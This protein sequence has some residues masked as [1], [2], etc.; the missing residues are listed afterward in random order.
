[1]SGERTVVAP[2][3]EFELPFS[4]VN[5]KEVWV[6]VEYVGTLTIV[7][8]ILNTVARSEVHWSQNLPFAIWTEESSLTALPV[9]K[10]FVKSKD[11][12]DNDFHPGCSEFC[13]SFIFGH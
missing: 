13:H 5:F 9:F 7:V 8:N 1:M 12:V 10:T 6:V 3:V 11:F 4:V 2:V